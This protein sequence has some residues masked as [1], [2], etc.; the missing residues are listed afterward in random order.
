ME[1]KGNFTEQSNSGSGSR[2]WETGTH[3]TVFSGKGV[4]QIS[5]AYPS[6]NQFENPYFRNPHINFTTGINK[7]RLVENTVID[8]TEVLKPTSLD[9]NG[10]SLTTPK[11]IEANNITC[12]GGSITCRNLTVNNTFTT[13]GDISASGDLTVNGLIF[14][15]AQVTVGGNCQIDRQLKMKNANDYLLVNGNLTMSINYNS[16]DSLTAGTVEVKG[17]FTEQSNSGSGSRYWETGTHKTIFSGR[18]VQQIS[19]SDPSYNRFATLILRNRS[20]EGVVFNSPV[21]VSTLFDHNRC[22]FT[23]Y[24]DGNG[25]SFNDFD[26]DGLL[27]HQDDYPTIPYPAVCGDANGDSRININDV[28]A[29]QRHLA[30]IEPLTDVQLILADTN[31]DGVV[32]INDATHLQNYLAEFDGIVLG[33]QR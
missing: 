18:S 28:T 33:K 19:F 25:S 7:L 4:Q 5:F 11:D 6:Y 9:L 2:Y 22:A 16:S 20:Q 30:E 10:F 15:N 29:I 8:S 14:N 26:G 32:N 31:G 12:S 3:K 23:L 24:D 13:D 27:D 21:T 17:N 1:V